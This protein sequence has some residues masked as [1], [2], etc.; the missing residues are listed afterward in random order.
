MH[1]YLD[2]VIV[3]IV[4]LYIEA[5]YYNQHLFVD[6]LA[7][8]RGSEPLAATWNGGHTSRRRHFRR[9]VPFLSTS[10]NQTKKDLRSFFWEANFQNSKNHPKTDTYDTYVYKLNTKLW[11]YALMCYTCWLCLITG[12]MIFQKCFGQLP[13]VHEFRWWSVW[14]VVWIVYCFSVS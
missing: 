13:R 1:Q 12:P 5:Q 4:D 8:R 2:L 6:K 9:F 10:T 14:D 7:E 3:Y 11:L